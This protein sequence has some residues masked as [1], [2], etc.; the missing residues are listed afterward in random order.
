MLVSFQEKPYLGKE[1]KNQLVGQST[2]YHLLVN[3]SNGSSGSNGSAA[4]DRSRS[5]NGVTW[6]RA[7]SPVEW[8]RSRSSSQRYSQTS[9][10]N[11]TNSSTVYY[12]GQRHPDMQPGDEAL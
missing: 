9:V 2:Q 5:P 1:S 4:W 3:N 10:R 8:E 11:S 12:P 7:K 6:D